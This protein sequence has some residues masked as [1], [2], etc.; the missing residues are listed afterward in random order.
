MNIGEF[1]KLLETASDETDLSSILPTKEVVKLITP[2][3]TSDIPI[4]EGACARIKHSVN[5][6]DLVAAMGCVKKYHQLAKRKAIMVQT[7]GFPAAYYTGAEHPIVDETGKNVSVNSKIWD[8]IKPLI[9]SQEYI[10]SF[11]KYEGQPIDIDF[12]VIRGKT[13]VNIPHGTIQGWLPLAFPDL[14][15]DI[16][17][18]WIHIDDNCPLKIKYQVANKILLN[19]TSRYRAKIDYYFLQKYAPDLI[20]SGTEKEHWDFCN[21]WNLTIPRLEI[22]NFLDLAYAVKEAR[23]SMGNQ[24]MLWNLAQAMGTKRILEMCSYAANC[25]PGIGADSHGYFY[26]VGAEYY[27][28]LLYNKT[29]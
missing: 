6:G 7:I 4:E 15:F 10:H 9:E 29:N 3:I 24:S 14:A 2:E 21:Q 5:I 1:K 25:F 11:E 23:F 18:P 20:F 8:M 27:W 17:V 13:Q 12:D 19:F 16:S 26:Q 22:D 28:R